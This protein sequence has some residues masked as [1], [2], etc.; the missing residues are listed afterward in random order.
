MSSPKSPTKSTRQPQGAAGSRLGLLYYYCNPKMFLR[1]DFYL[2]GLRGGALTFVAVLSVLALY[3]VVAAV[4]VMNVIKY[5]RGRTPLRK[6]TASPKPP[7]GDFELAEKNAGKPVVPD[8]DSVQE[9]PGEMELAALR[10]VM[11]SPELIPEINDDS[12][13]HDVTHAVMSDDDATLIGQE[14]YAAAKASPE[15]RPVIPAVPLEN[16]FERPISPPATPPAS[17]RP[18]IPIVDIVPDDKFGLE[19]EPTGADKLVEKAAEVTTGIVE[20]AAQAVAELKQVVEEAK[21][22][23]VVAPPEPKLNEV[24]P[25]SE[26]VIVFEPE[27]P[28][29]DP[30]QE[31][32]SKPVEVEPTPAKVL[33]DGP[34]APVQ[35]KPEEPA[36]ALVA[37]PES[38]EA[39]KPVEASLPVEAPKPVEEVK[40][41]VVEEPE[42]EP[43][44]VEEPKF[45]EEPEVEEPKPIQVAK[46]KESPK[47]TFATPA[48]APA[49]KESPTITPAPAVPKS[50]GRPRVMRRATGSTAAVAG[51]TTSPASSAAIATAPSIAEDNKIG[52]VNLLAGLRSDS[53]GRSPSP[54]FGRSNSPA[55]GR[56]ASPALGRSASPAPRS[57]SPAQHL[58]SDSPSSDAAGSRPASP[59]PAPGS[60]ARRGSI[61][62][63]GGKPGISRQSTLANV[64][65]APPRQPAPPSS[66]LPVRPSSRQS[67]YSNNPRGGSASPPPMPLPPQRQ[68]SLGRSGSPPPQGPQAA[69]LSPSILSRKATLDANGSPGSPPVPNSARR[70]TSPAR[71]PAE[72]FSTAGTTSG[73]RRVPFPSAPDGGQAPV[74]SSPNTTPNRP[75]PKPRTSTSNSAGAPNMLQA[76]LLANLTGKSQVPSSPDSN[77]SSNSAS[78]VRR[79]SFASAVSKRDSIFSVYEFSDMDMSASDLDFTG[80]EGHRVGRLNSMSSI[81]STDGD[82]EG[83]SG[84]EEEKR[85]KRAK[86]RAKAKAQAMKKQKR[87]KR[88]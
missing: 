59:S 81:G 64:T 18:E 24:S 62:L 27:S 54:A 35:A 58:R 11:P 84:N 9:I 75:R 56:S 65:N 73:R 42:Q 20:A 29:V 30:G 36:V 76:S 21:L 69:V 88:N 53:S 4:S 6:G 67:S 12:D 46:P 86:R 16:K 83:M 60:M 55:L 15:V 71:A 61:A 51:V 45:V 78:P 5:I 85:K 3:S 8:L 25:N 49:P 33:V 66:S 39:P 74:T 41:V 63:S 26:F 31:E 79:D 37:E 77:G 57:S 22:E 13:E 48:P 17:T 32:P 19:E 23:P 2:A 70:T 28:A 68:P 10:D 82:S 50:L 7:P 80:R 44:L 47:Q 72:E 38:V 40:P 34:S 52:A 1:R 43:K 14:D 87:G